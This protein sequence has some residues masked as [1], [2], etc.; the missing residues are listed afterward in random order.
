MGALAV[1]WRLQMWG[2]EKETIS[3]IILIH[4]WHIKSCGC[5]HEACMETQ[6]TVQQ[7]GEPAYTSVAPKRSNHEQYGT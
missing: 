2:W 6:A 1:S 4:L 7:Q 5:T 3:C